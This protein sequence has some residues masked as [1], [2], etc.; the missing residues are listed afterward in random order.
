MLQTL[1]PMVAEML[2]QAVIDSSFKGAKFFLDEHPSF[3]LYCR[4]FSA[5]S[6]STRGGASKGPVA[7]SPPRTGGLKS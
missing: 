7:K 4:N 5:G 6:R 2:I 1:F 3:S